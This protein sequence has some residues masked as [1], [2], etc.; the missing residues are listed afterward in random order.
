[1]GYPLAPPRP[2]PPVSSR[3]PAPAPLQTSAFEILLM[4]I[5][6]GKSFKANATQSGHVPV[7][8]ANG[9]FAYIV[10]M[11]TV[12]FLINTGRLVP[13]SLRCPDATGVRERAE[14]QKKLKM[15]RS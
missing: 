15:E 10:T 6:P 14:T 4:V 9:M 3:P 11:A 2:A 8:K 5:L 13:L 12:C 1:M 7:Y